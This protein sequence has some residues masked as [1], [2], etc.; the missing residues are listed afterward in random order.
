MRDLF[1]A[2]ME[3]L[4]G[5]LAWTHK[6]FNESGNPLLVSA[7][8]AQQMTPNASAE[9]DGDRHLISMHEALFVTLQEFANFCFAQQAF[10]ADIGEAGSEASP[11][12]MSEDPPGLWLL[13]ETQAGMRE[14]P[15]QASRMVPMCAERAVAAV[16]LTQLMARFVWLHELAHCV[17]G[18]V[19]LVR[20][21][22]LALRLCEIHDAETLGIVS[23]EPKQ[24]DAR[25]QVFQALE[26]DADR[27]ALHGC[28]SIQM[29]DLENIQGIAALP[30]GLRLR[31]ALF[32]CY[33]MA[34]LFDSYRAFT[35][36]AFGTTHPEPQL[37]LHAMV[38]FTETDIALHIDGFSTVQESIAR[39]FS[40]LTECLPTIALPTKVS[41]HLG[42][43]ELPNDLIA[44]YRYRD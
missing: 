4:N 36:S 37:R 42:I 30:L 2:S 31:L 24:A 33:S 18:H 23:H 6:A 20:D 10:F 12:P 16:Y 7:R 39:E 25:D 34:W 14:L 5:Q 1:S 27:T 41:Q 15:A 22:G 28:I 19:D 40:V 8:F 17:N 21:Q 9:R 11:A 32:G 43:P 44:R 26:V 38:G 3:S 35:G 13:R 29:N